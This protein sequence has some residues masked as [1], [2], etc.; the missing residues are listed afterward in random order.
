MTA[1]PCIVQS[2]RHDGEGFHT[3][4]TRT[5]RERR[6]AELDAL[7]RLGQHAGYMRSQ[8]KGARSWAV[9]HKAKMVPEFDM[10][11]SPLFRDR[12]LLDFERAE[13]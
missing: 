13:S 3:V 10:V 6:A 4:E 9:Y 7:E 12:I 5:K 11:T 2:M 8:V 1:K